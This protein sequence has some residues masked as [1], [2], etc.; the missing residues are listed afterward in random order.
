[1]SVDLDEV[2]NYHAIHG[3]PLPDASTAN[4]VY[5]VALERIQTFA[6][7]HSLPLTLFAIGADLTRRSNADKLREL[8]TRG[9]ELANHSLDHRYDL[10]RL[11]RA[12]ME[13]Q[14]LGGL[15][16]LRES[17]GYV[18]RGFRAP[19]YTTSDVLMDVVA[20][21]GATYDSSVFPCPPYYLA[22][23][24]ALA[25]FAA[26]GRRSR[27]LL[28]T[29]AVLA[30]PTVPYRVGR[31]Y[32]RRGSGLLELP[33]QVTRGARLPY[34]GTALTMAGAAGARWL[35]RAVIGQPFVNLELHGIDFLDRGDGLEPL[36][37]HQPDVGIPVRKK[38]DA[39]AAAIN[40]LKTAGYAFVRL[41]EAAAEVCR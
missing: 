4:L 14:V 35:T 40:G 31:P 22:K 16:R 26:R 28:D 23:L 20:S 37:R 18:A 25:L 21:S 39:L 12:E 8:A 17:T 2:P 6:S 1:V 13:R 3:L 34:I 5:A 10:T 29:P 11:P 9:H 27:S 41:D 15:E 36:V 7:V 38:L 19:G 24:S 30:A 32:Y 33:V